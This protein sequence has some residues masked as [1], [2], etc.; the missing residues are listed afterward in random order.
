MQVPSVSIIYATREMARTET[1]EEMQETW[2]QALGW[3]GPLEEEMITHSG[4]LSWEIPWTEE[5]RGLQ[6]RESQSVGHDWVANTNRCV[7]WNRHSGPSSRVPVCMH[8]CVHVGHVC[9]HAYLW[10]FQ[11]SGNRADRGHGSWRGA[12]HGHGVAACSSRVCVCVCTCTSAPSWHA[13]P[14]G[15]MR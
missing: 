13:C 8:L 10:F 15:H 12:G 2:V 11:H 3:D 5:P 14:R 7:F 6:S 4:I 9:A 1:A